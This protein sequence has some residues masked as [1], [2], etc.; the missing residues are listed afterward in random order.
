MDTSSSVATKP[1]VRQSFILNYLPLAMKSTAR[2]FPHEIADMPI[3]LNFMLMEESIVQSNAQWA[4]RYIM[5]LW[6][7]LIAMIPFDLAKFDDESNLGHTARS[8]ERIGKTYLGK[9]GLERDG[10]ALLLSRLY[11]R[12]VI[13]GKPWVH[14]YSAC[15]LQ[16]R[17]EVRV[18]GASSLAGNTNTL[19]E[20]R[21]YHGRFGVYFQVLLWLTI[22]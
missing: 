16:K 20:H 14:R 19:P 6:L 11:L 8:L 9:A 1:S 2:F 3:A 15:G 12:C 13:R 21:R 4:L 18:S 17:Y 22:L 7:S 5:M 10:A